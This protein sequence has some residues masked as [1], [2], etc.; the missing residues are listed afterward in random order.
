MGAFRWIQ[1][2]A[3]AGVIAATVGSMADATPSQAPVRT[4]GDDGRKVWALPG[5][6]DGQGNHPRQVW[7]DTAPFSGRNLGEDV[8]YDLDDVLRPVS[9]SGLASLPD[10][11]VAVRLVLGEVGA[12]RVLESRFGQLEAMGVI[13]T[14]LHRMDPVQWN[15]ADVPGL[16]GWP[17]CGDGATFASCA[18]PQQYYGIASARALNPR[19]VWTDQSQLLDAVDVIVGAWWMLDSGIVADVTNG[20]TS[21][22]HR[23]GGTHYGEPYSQ[24]GAAEQVV[25]PIRFTG[26]RTFLRSEGRYEMGVTRLIDYK[27]GGT[28][29]EPSAYATYLWGDNDDVAWL[30]DDG[31]THGRSLREWQTRQR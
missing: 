28:F 17:G 8:L 6:L 4:T 12:M 11:A 18:N 15:P 24:C 7:V 10:W 27:S 23:C 31:S 16:R 2:F 3:V 1:T 13:E 20:A 9:A 21:F 25:G 19:A 22:T 26:P 29:V 5:V 30:D 14:V